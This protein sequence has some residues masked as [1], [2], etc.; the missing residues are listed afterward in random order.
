VHTGWAHEEQ[1]EDPSVTK[2]LNFLCE[3]NIAIPSS[4]RK[5]SIKFML[6]KLQELKG[7]GLEAE[8]RDS[9]GMEAPSTSLWA[10]LSHF[11]WQQQ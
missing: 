8:E 5:L 6:E 11:H 9:V 10:V 1:E 4:R 7:L 2:I 3:H